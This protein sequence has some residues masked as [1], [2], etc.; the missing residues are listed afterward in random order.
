MDIFNKSH[1][2]HALYKEYL[3]T[4]RKHRRKMV[5]CV[6]KNTVLITTLAAI[7]HYLWG[8]L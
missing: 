5:K 7:I 2:H 3:H 1:K 4:K 6:F 8:I